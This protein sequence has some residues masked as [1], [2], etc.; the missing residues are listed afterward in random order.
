MPAFEEHKFFCLNCGRQGIPI[1][2]KK[3]QQHGAFHRKKLY[4]PWC[5]VTINHIECRNDEE[6]KE[7][8]EHFQKGEYQNE[9]KESLVVSRGAWIR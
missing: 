5:K 8:L 7:F 1:R 3:G 2:R 6:V 4:C 9:A